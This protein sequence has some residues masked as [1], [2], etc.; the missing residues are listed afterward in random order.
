MAEEFFYLR[1]KLKNR[2]RNR[3]M[4]RAAGRLVPSGPVFARSEGL[5]AGVAGVHA[6]GFATQKYNFL[7]RETFKSTL[8]PVEESH[9]LLPAAYSDPHFFELEKEKVFN[10]AWV[11]AGYTTELP[12]IGDTK[13]LEVGGQSILITRDKN[14]NLKGFFNVCRHRGSRIVTDDGV[15]NHK[16]RV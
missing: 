1:R 5:A 8:R 10:R 13:S 15:S 3:N 4:K 12:N 6:R 14:G 11:C 2:F 16:V 7:D 9:S